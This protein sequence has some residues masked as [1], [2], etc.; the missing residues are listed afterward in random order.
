[1]GGS[2]SWLGEDIWVAVLAAVD[3]R[4]GD[5]KREVDAI[6]A[7]YEKLGSLVNNLNSINVGGIDAFKSLA[8]AVT[9][10]DLTAAGKVKDERLKNIDTEKSKRLAAIEMQKNAAIRAAGDKVFTCFLIVQSNCCP[11][12]T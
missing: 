12:K 7:G 11:T 2:F 6:A 1:M 10:Y 9:N 3:A 4:L 5:Y 8:D